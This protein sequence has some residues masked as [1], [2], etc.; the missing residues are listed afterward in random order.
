MKGIKL[1]L[2]I[3]TIL[4]AMSFSPMIFAEEGGG[5]GNSAW[6]LAIGAGLAI[7]LAALGGALGQG[8]AAEG[9]LNGI[10]RNPGAYKQLFLS[11]IL[12]L[13]FVE[14]LVLFSLII[15]YMIQK[16]IH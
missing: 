12:S 16:N 2:T 3:T 9:A 13:G 5:T 10:A 4:V 6:G 8:R 7:G 11:L 1:F 14:S 15:S